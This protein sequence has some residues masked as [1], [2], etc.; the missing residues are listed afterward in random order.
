MAVLEDGSATYLISTRG[1][2]VHFDPVTGELLGT[3]Q[4][5]KRFLRGTAQLPDGSLLLGDHNNLLLFDLKR[6][7]IISSIPISDNPLYFIIS[8]QVSPRNFG[9]PPESFIEH[10]SQKMPVGQA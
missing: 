6:G 8:T 2:L 9:F 10:H 3:Y 1:E 4:L 5:G 7:R